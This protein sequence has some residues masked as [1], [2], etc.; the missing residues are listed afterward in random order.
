MSKGRKVRLII[1]ILLIVIIS[2]YV[3][4]H[5]KRKL[6]IK[7]NI[8]SYIIGD[9]PDIIIDCNNLFLCFLNI[10]FSIYIIIGNT[11]TVYGTFRLSRLNLYFNSTIPNIV[12]DDSSNVY[13]QLSS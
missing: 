11:N 10:I 3:S 7:E 9:I 1:F 6:I 4:T 2:I 8:N 12:K 5:A 13:I